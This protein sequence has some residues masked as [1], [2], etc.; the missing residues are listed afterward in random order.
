MIFVFL[1][2]RVTVNGTA[3]SIWKERNCRLFEGKSLSAQKEWGCFT[4]I[5]AAMFDKNKKIRV[6]HSK[7]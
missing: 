7:K 4:Q 6:L 5:Q 3:W 2:L 1:P